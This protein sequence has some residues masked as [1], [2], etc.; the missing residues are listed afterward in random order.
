MVKVNEHGNFSAGLAQVMVTKE[1]SVRPPPPET[2]TSASVP[3]LPQTSAPA[4]NN[5]INIVINVPTSTNSQSS[6]GK[7]TKDRVAAR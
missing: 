6:T 5:N 2:I 1:S 3:S 4:T 7:K